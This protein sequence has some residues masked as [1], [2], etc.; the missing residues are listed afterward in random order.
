MLIILLHYHKCVV[1]DESIIDRSDDS[2]TLGFVS[3]VN[4]Y[5]T[6]N[7]YSKALDS[8]T[9]GFVRVVVKGNAQ[10]G[11]VVRL[12]FSSLFNTTCHM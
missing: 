6:V 5:S 1:S 3:K 10:N 9:L 8:A 2:A 4:T 12:P 7:P 11:L